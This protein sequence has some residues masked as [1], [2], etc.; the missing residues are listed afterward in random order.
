MATAYICIIIAAVMPVILAAYAKLSVKGYD[1]NNPRE[2]LAKLDGRAKRANFAHMNAFE[3]FPFFAAGVII[4]YLAG[5]DPLKIDVL[6]MAFIA[7]RIIYSLCYIF[8][9]SVLRSINW[10]LAF[11]CPLTMIIEG[12]TKS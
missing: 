8:D 7:F 1:N 2:F 3:A 11:L 10:F 6:S 9:K 4:A 5:V 12:I